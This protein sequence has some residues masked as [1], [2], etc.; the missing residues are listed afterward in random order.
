MKKI[1]YTIIYRYKNINF[2]WIIIQKIILL[3]GFKKK[4][5]EYLI[6]SD[7]IKN[8]YIIIDYVVDG[9]NL[10]RKI[11]TNKIYRKLN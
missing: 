11:L 9:V 1:Y 8:K 3:K 2:Q 4:F 7:E 10:K 5:C 6:F